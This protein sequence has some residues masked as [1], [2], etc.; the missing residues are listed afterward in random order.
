[1][2][3]KRRWKGPLIS[4]SFVPL[5]MSNN[6]ELLLRPLN[7]RMEEEL[8]DCGWI[9]GDAIKGCG[10]SSKM[11]LARRLGCS[12]KKEEKIG[13]PSSSSF[14]F[15]LFSFFLITFL[16]LLSLFFFLVNFWKSKRLLPT[17][18]GVLRKDG[19]LI[20][21]LVL[22]FSLARVCSKAWGVC[23]SWGFDS[24][25]LIWG[26]DEMDLRVLGFLVSVI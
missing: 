5:S 12:R 9:E 10:C 25:R 13:T 18:N 3:P 4:I 26:G 7:L 20:G 21:F 19:D 24:T 23:N 22:G 11:V 15:F 14:F 2:C 17:W 1:M 6:Q 16:L 8:Q